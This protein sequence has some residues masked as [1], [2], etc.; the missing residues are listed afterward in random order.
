[1]SRSLSED[2]TDSCI[3]QLGKLLGN[4]VLRKGNLPTIPMIAL[5]SSFIPDDDAVAILVIRSVVVTT[6]WAIAKHFSCH[7][8]RATS[9]PCRNRLLQCMGQ[10][11]CILNAGIHTLPAG[12]AVNVC[13]IAGQQDSAL[14]QDLGNAM[15][16]LKSR[17]PT[18]L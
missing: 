11:D 2:L 16:A 3:V 12:G 8:F 9:F 17:S 4:G 10:R 15:L 13:G 6:E 1:V 18:M 14:T 5:R 7:F